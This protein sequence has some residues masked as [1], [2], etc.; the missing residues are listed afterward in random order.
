M[1]KV[2]LEK[3]RKLFFEAGGHISNKKIADDVG[4]NSLTVGRWKTK[5]NWPSKLL[6]M[7]AHDKL[8]MM[9]VRKTEERDR[10]FEIYA[11]SRGGIGN[12]E[13]ALIVDVA[14]ATIGK[15]KRSGRWHERLMEPVQVFDEEVFDASAAPVELVEPEQEIPEIECKAQAEE[16]EEVEVD[17]RSEEPQE[18]ASIDIYRLVAPELIVLLNERMATLLTREHLS[19]AEVADLA[20]AKSDLLD[21]AA[22]CI[23]ILRGE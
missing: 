12:K 6:E 19:T 7:Q 2:E 13:L 1:K 8:S 3:A 10:A 14:P 23:E 22:K 16:L 18:G 15:W 4:V 11:A 5:E 21:A 9:V 17:D 20:E